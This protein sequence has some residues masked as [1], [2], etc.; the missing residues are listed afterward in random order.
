MDKNETIAAALLPLLGGAGNIANVSN[1][2]TRMRVTPVDR[3]LFDEDAIKKTPGV[4]GIVD[5][6]TYQIVLGPG[7]VTKV[8][9]AFSKMVE[10]G[11]AAG[12]T[13]PAAGRGG[14]DADM[15]AKGAAMKAAQKARTTPRSR[16]CCA[17]SRTSSSR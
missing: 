8:T 1:C 4:M 10:E 2:I 6:E 14:A 9:T 5:D 17:R 12:A 13:V 16:T 11:K 7:T 15:A 3:S